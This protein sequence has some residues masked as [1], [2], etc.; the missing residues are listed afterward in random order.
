[1]VFWFAPPLSPSWTE[2]YHVHM[3]RKVNSLNGQINQTMTYKKSC[4]KFRNSFLH[5]F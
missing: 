3:I 2:C 5:I 1:L 4:L